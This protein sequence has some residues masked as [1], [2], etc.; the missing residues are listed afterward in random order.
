MMVLTALLVMQDHKP[1]PS[2]LDVDIRRAIAASGAEVAVA[3]RRLDRRTSSSS[4]R[5]LHFMPRAR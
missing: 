2:P 1:P 4:T 5:T 3:Y